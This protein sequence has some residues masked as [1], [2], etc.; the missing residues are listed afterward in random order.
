MYNLI[1]RHRW[2]FSFSWISQI[3]TFLLAAFMVFVSGY[4]PRHGMMG[5]DRE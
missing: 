5:D 2:I 3:V 1:L 4:L